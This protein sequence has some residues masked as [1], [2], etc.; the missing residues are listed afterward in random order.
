MLFAAIAAPHRA[1]D[2]GYRMISFFDL[3]AVLVLLT[4]TFGWINR[5]FF[6][7]PSNIGLLL[8]GVLSSLLLLLLD[9]LIPKANLLNDFGAALKKIDFYD[10]VMNGMLAFLLFAGAL[11]VDWQRL[12]RRFGSV[13]ALATLGVL[14]STFLVGAGFWLLAGFFGINLPLA[15]ALVFGALISPTDPVA[16]LSMLK[17][18]RVPELLETEIAGESLFND[19]VGVVLFTLLL[20]IADSGT[21]EFSI[22][23]AVGLFLLEAIGGALFGL[24]AGYA[25]FQAMRLID[26]YAVEVFI[27]LALVTTTYAL[28]GHAHIS[29]PIAVVVA[30][31]L[32]GERGPT[33]AM[34]ERT[35]RYLFSFWTV[36]DEILNSILFLLIG[37]ELLV[38]EFKLEFGGLALCVIPLVLLARL[39]AIGI[40]VSIMRMWVRFIKGSIAVM[41]W[42][43][44]RGG[45]SIALALSIP[46]GDERTVILTATYAVV[47]FTVIVQG[48]TMPV[49]IRRAVRSAKLPHKRHK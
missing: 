23:S 5:K 42:G 44:I 9:L 40:P 13:T 34:S 27:S 7:L 30:G 24:L 10:A 36:I 25:A 47:L 46:Y 11:H 21:T 8:M 19:G 15:W 48:L 16:V 1:P 12:K 4:A 28:A 38:L 49:V 20:S 32:I 3:F 22:W 31:L 41:V 37:L 14:I 39:A 17:S 18:M 29:G 45:I 26:D 33:H 2:Q 43:G 35:Q 6:G